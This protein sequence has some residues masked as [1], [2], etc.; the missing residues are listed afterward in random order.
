MLRHRTRTMIIEIHAATFMSF[1]P[2]QYWMTTAAADIS[3][4]RVIEH[5]YQFFSEISIIEEPG[6][7]TEPHEYLRSNQRRILEHHLHNE[8]RIGEWILE[9]EAM[10][11]FHPNSSSWQRQQNQ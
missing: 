10:L 6:S 9:E 8:R 2:S 7:R 1:A 11:P 4:Q 5:E 3:T